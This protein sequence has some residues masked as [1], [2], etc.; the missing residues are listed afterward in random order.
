MTK[1]TYTTRFASMERTF[2][3]PEKAA[4]YAITLKREMRRV[5]VAILTLTVDGVAWS[6]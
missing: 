4:R 5:G 3:T 1:V 2:T 6:A